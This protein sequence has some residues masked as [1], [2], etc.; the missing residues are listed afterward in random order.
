MTE[1]E[2][3][4][5]YYAMVRD[6]AG[7]TAETVSLPEDATVIVLINHLIGLYGDRFR[8]YVYDDEGRLLDYLMF[9]VNEVDIRSLDGFDTVLRDGDRVSM[10]PPIGGG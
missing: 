4:L 6:A 7:K 3:E 5:R 2:V 10:M 9:S 8:G 1:L